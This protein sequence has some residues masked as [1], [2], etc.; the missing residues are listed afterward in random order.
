[1]SIQHKHKQ[2][3][4]ENLILRGIK[5]LDFAF[6][7]PIY[8]FGGIFGA[9]FLD[10][11]IYKYFKVVNNPNIQDDTTIQLFTN[12]VILLF[13]NTV[14]GY[15]LSYVL[16]KI[17]FPLDNVYGFKHKQVREVRTGDMITLILLI[18]SN[19]IT[20]YIVEIQRRY[21][22]NKNLIQ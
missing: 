5:I 3:L 4:K 21:I 11:Y 1:M 16:Q 22:K 6:I 18:F 15:I 12:V 7:I 19:E 10:N 13:I 9:I 14:V 20:R 2:T 17:P 8:A